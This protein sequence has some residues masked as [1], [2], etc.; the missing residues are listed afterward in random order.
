MS[1][2]IFFYMFHEPYLCFRAYPNASKRKNANPLNKQSMRLTSSTS[3]RSRYRRRSSRSRSS[4]RNH[5][6]HFLPHKRLPRAA[7][8]LGQVLHL[9][10][11]HLVKKFRHS[12][13]VLVELL[14]FGLSVLVFGAE[15]AKD[16]EFL[17]FAGESEEFLDG[18]VLG[19]ECEFC[20]LN[21]AFII[22]LLSHRIPS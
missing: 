5:T 20:C 11:F 14:L 4:R 17:D 3:S 18:G 1:D 7:A 16:P 6:L 12:V 15:G 19:R 9:G 13:D 21:A 8:A 22:N 2:G 10:G